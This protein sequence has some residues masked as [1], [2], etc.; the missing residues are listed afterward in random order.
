MARIK[1]DREP[2]LCGVCR[3]RAYGY[4]VAPAQ[5]KPVMWLCDSPECWA[6]GQ[7]VY[8]MPTA[9]LDEFEK[10]A[11]DAAGERAGAYLDSIGKTDLAQLTGEEW[12]LFLHQVIVGFEDELRAI[13]RKSL[14]PF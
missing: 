7:G 12:R 13:F 5:S 6:L 2:V 14:A 4:G 9:E 1:G 8:T 3:R 10:A 11:R